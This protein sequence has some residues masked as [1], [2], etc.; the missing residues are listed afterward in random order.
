MR[1]ACL[2]G[3]LGLVVASCGS[4]TAAPSSAPPATTP[5]T[6]TTPTATAFSGTLTA[7]NGGQVLAGVTVSSGGTTDAGGR[8]TVPAAIGSLTFSGAS[9]LTRVVNLQQ[10]DHAFSADAIALSGGFDVA[11]YRAFVRN[12][13]EAPNV[14]Q[15]LRRL[16]AAPNIYLRTIDSAGQPIDAVT[17]NATA[18]ALRDVASTWSGGRFG[19]ASVTQGTDSRIGVSGWITVTWA[20]AATTYCGQS[21]V[22][23]DG[24]NIDLAPKSQGCGCPPSVSTVAIRPRTVKHELGHAFG[25]WHTGNAADLMSGLAVAQCDQ[26]PSERERYHAAI[27]YS[28]APGNLDPDIDPAAVALSHLP[29]AAVVSD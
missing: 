8:F 4:S 23:R 11:F 27:A 15:Q 6:P 26:D 3:L 20:A 17:L 18:T 1:R 21:D 13:S 24:G 12:G 10:P 19:I 16:T 9:I 29:A 22:G 25:Y 7:T 14:L 2:I 28:R 5:A